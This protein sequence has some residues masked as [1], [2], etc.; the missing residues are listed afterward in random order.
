MNCQLTSGVAGLL[1][2]AGGEVEQDG[3]GRQHLLAPALY[4]TDVLNILT[5]TAGF[6][7]VSQ[8][9]VGSAGQLAW[10]LVK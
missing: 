7:L 4:P 2:S 5:E 3:R 9:A 8:S 10:S 1:V 6:S